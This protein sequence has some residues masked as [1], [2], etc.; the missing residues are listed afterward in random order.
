ML[1]SFGLG[2]LRVYLKLEIIS[3]KLGE[4]LKVRKDLQCKGN[5]NKKSVKKYLKFQAHKT[6]G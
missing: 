2:F 5:K 6:S 4:D 1:G 3:Q